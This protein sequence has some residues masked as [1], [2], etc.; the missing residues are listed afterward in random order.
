M[1]NCV[2]NE[3]KGENDEGIQLKVF[4]IHS[5]A[6]EI[7]F[8]LFSLRLSFKGRKNIYKKNCENF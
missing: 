5:K 8:I 4:G 7:Y 2:E 1:I 3:I 6:D